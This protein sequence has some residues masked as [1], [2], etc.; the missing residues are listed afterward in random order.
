MEEI[1]DSVREAPL[2]FRNRQRKRIGW[3]KPFFIFLVLVLLILI[4]VLAI[5]FYVGWDLTHPDT[6]PINDS[7]QSYGLP[8]EEIVIE[9]ALDQ[10]RLAGWLLQTELEPKALVVM[11]HGYRGNRLEDG[12]P[13][14]SLAQ[15]FLDSGYHVY[16][17]DFR[18]SGDSEG[19]TTTV[20]YHEKYDLISIVEVGLQRF[21]DIP[22]GVVGFSMGASTAIIA[23][24]DD[25]NISFVVADSPFSDLHQYLSQNLSIW[26]N[27]PYIPFTPFI[28]GIMTAV[29]QVDIEQ[30]SPIN[31]IA[32]MEVP[33]LLIH[34]GEDTTISDRNSQEI[35]TNRS[36]E[37]VQYWP[38]QGAS[39]LQS[40]SVDPQAY[41][42]RVESFIDQ[43]IHP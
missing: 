43:S 38:V 11:A 19:Q 24:A 7:P 6:K 34:G 14:L 5:S 36:G 26:S 22:I 18:N 37:H 40:Y 17:F 28:L 10:T 13:A 21:P 4:S 42:E 27:L 8:Y 9:S 29:L 16:M 1:P 32:S 33:V 25:T 12:V 2:A 3:K 15:D 31:V 30:V 41:F 23:A 20:G 35:W 39:H